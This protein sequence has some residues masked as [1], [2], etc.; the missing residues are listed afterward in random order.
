[1]LR[2]FFLSIALLL[3]LRVSAQEAL[4]TRIDSVKEGQSLIEFL[5][6]V[7]AS[8][9]VRFFYL[10]EWLEPY[11]TFSEFNGLT[12]REILIATL[13][14][15][16]L[17]FVFLYDYAVI[18]YKDP[19]REIERNALVKTAKQN[20]I[21]VTEITLGDRKELVPGKKIVLKGLVK[22]KD[23]NTS[24][25]GATV[26]ISGLNFGISTGPDG[27]YSVVIP[28]G[29]YTVSY[30]YINF[31]EKLVDLS[32]YKD[33]EVN[34]GLEENPRMLR[35]VII[36]GEHTTGSRAGLSNIRM[37]ELKRAP[38]F[39]GVPDLIKQIQVESG[40]TTVSEATSGFNV[41]GGGVDQN[42]IVYD[43]V[44]VFNTA[45]ALGFF[46]AFNS[47]AIQDAVFYKGAIPAEY[48]GRVSS[49]LNITS[50]EGSYQKWNGNAGLGFVSSNVMAG[51]P[52]KKDTS[53]LTLSFRSSYSDWVLDLLKTKYKNISDGS[54]FFYDAS[55]KYSHKLTKNSKLTFS[56]YYSND[57]FQLANDTVNKWQNATFAAR[58]YKTLRS[59]LFYNVGVYLGRYAYQVSD[60]HSTNAFTLDYSILYPSLKIDFN[61]E[62]ALHKQTF[63][64][65]TTYYRFN[66]GKLRP[67]SADSNIDRITMPAEQS[68][69]T[70]LY[71]GD[72]FYW[73]S[74][75]NVEL[76]LRLS[77]YNRIGS[78]VKYIYEPGEPREPRNTVDSV[79][80]GSGEIMKTYVGPEPRVSLS[81]SLTELAS[82]KFGYNR[83]YQYVHLITNTASVTPVDIW[84]ISN[85]HFKPQIAN[86]VSL[87]YFRN[88]KGNSVSA[89]AEIYY[90]Y[91]QNILD[92]KD[93]ASLILNPQLETSLLRGTSRAYGIEFTISKRKGRLTGGLNYT[94][95]RSLRRVNGKFDTEKVNEGK[96]Y[97]S[98][99]D[100]PHVANLTWRYGLTRKV[101][102]TG[103]FTMHT[104]RPVSLPIGGYIIDGTPVSNF[105]ERNNYRLPMYHRLDLALIIEGSNRKKKRLQSHWTFSVYNVY[106]RKNP[107]SVFY[108]DNGG[109]VLQPYQLSLIGTAVPSVTYSC[110]F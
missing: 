31:Q 72:S 49:V 42:L 3:A 11:T 53:S 86:Q 48:G 8:G 84:Q 6:K 87:G 27:R 35:E 18:F 46:T 89:S 47:D 20:N 66:P 22:N 110:K 80:Y 13:K 4:D 64:F 56:A 90:K 79:Y 50:S 1:M 52:I 82:V 109:G 33:G 19:A 29:E 26:F 107:Y 5:E 85:A 100:Q 70:A 98:N 96:T 94:F 77:M 14:D 30:R 54:V 28:G 41:R 88:Y 99:Y 24:L 34:I 2:V 101:F 92:F 25:A 15:S 93:G 38:S 81:Y 83:M 16:D 60:D 9:K 73:G 21:D 105:S 7:E 62:G 104:G 55:A 68:F 12:L 51:G 36:S 43:G 61:R 40:V 10:A 106:G 103:N 69:E 91:I 45:H 57:R 102:F 95:S 76:G 67:T 58:Y 74:K 75:L 108:N 32:I 59:D 23:N 97:A 71:F 65:H 63:G 44:P 39:L 78:G 37:D 17:N